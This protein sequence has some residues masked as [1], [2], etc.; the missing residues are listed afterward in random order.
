LPKIEVE[1]PA[2]LGRHLSLEKATPPEDGKSLFPLQ[3]EYSLRTSFEK[4]RTSGLSSPME[5][6]EEDQLATGEE[7]SRLPA[8]LPPPPPPET[9]R[10]KDPLDVR[11]AMEDPPSFATLEEDEDR[12]DKDDRMTPSPPLISISNASVPDLSLTSPSASSLD[13]SLSSPP[14]WKFEA[15]PMLN[16]RQSWFNSTK[17]A[18][19]CCALTT[20]MVLATI[21]Y[22]II[23]AAHG[24]PQG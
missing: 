2:P 19:I 9:E 11:E 18:M 3:P 21:I 12:D 4:Y 5:E 24:Q 13:K 23:L 15:F 1:T 22:N 17:A 7:A 8:P 16:R 6:T 14:P 20:T 10:P